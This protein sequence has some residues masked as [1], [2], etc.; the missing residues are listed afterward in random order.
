MEEKK[1]IEEPEIEEPWKILKFYDEFDFD[2]IHYLSQR[3]LKCK[4]YNYSIPES[5]G[6][7]T[8]VL[9]YTHDTDSID[10]YNVDHLVNKSDRDDGEFII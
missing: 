2:P 10:I 4:K 8:V 6:C 1:T 9:K 5:F 3:I 7:S